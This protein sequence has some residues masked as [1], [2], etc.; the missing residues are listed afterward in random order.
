MWDATSVLQLLWRTSW[1]SAVVA[2]VVL[3]VRIVVGRTITHR[4]RHALWVLVLCRLM[5]PV[6]P[7]SRA[8]LFSLGGPVHAV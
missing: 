8:S 6:L 3:A 4:W 2:G 5:L 7:S 1:Q